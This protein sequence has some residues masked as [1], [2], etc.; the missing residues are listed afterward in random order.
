M[1]YS[2]LTKYGLLYPT[3]RPSSVLNAS[4]LE[5]RSGG[6]EHDQPFPVLGAGQRKG[7]SAVGLWTCYTFRSFGRL[8]RALYGCQFRNSSFNKYS[9]GRWC[10][11]GGGSPTRFRSVLTCSCL[12]V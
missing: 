6:D 8:H 3:R 12:I 4:D 7:H 11:G 5:S 2:S 9:Q 10:V 1:V